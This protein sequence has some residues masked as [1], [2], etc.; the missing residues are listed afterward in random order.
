MATTIWSLCIGYIIVSTLLCHVYYDHTDQDAPFWVSIGLL[1]YTSH[2]NAITFCQES[3]NPM[4]VQKPILLNLKRRPQRTFS[5]VTEIYEGLS[6][7]LWKIARDYKIC[8]HHHFTCAYS[9]Y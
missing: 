5:Q 9:F 3:P 2:L 4:A 1:T 6:P 7:P 8:Q